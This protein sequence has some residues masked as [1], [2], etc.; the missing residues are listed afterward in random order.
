MRPPRHI[1]IPITEA[2]PG[3]RFNGYTYKIIGRNGE[4]GTGYTLGDVIIG[5]DGTP[6]SWGEYPITD[7]ELFHYLRDMTWQEEAEWYKKQVDLE[8][9][10]HQLNL[11]GL[12]HDL[13]DV[14]DAFH[15]MWNG[16]VCAD[17]YEQLT[18]LIDEDFFIVGIAPAPYECWSLDDSVAIVAEVRRTGDR[19]WCHAGRSW[20]EDMREESLEQYKEL[21]K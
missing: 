10:I 16:W 15:E 4:P 1:E 3:D 21:M 14:G 18:E 17:W 13:Y 20:I 8:N 7:K 11:M 5:E 9:P 12:H 19:F 2:K 6:L